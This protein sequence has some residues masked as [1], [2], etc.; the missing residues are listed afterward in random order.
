VQISCTRSGDADVRTANHT[1]VAIWFWPTANITARELEAQSDI[2]SEDEHTRC[3]RM[4]AA[5]DRR[6]FTAA[7]GLLRRVL[8]ANG[9][10]RPEEWRFVTDERGKP[11]I[12]PEQ[13]GDPPLT[14]SL[15]HTRGL[16]ACAVAR[17][18]LIGIDVEA[19]E[20]RSASPDVASRFFAPAEVEMLR[21]HPPETYA[22]RFIEVWTLKESYIKALGV[23]LEQQLDS[24]AFFFPNDGGLRFE[25]PPQDTSESWRFVLCAPSSRFRLAVAVG[26]GDTDRGP[27]VTFNE[28]PT[29]L[30]VSEGLT[31]RP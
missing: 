29:I 2:L 22:D 15:S 27:I 6:D 16:V 23:G 3:D 8:S 5:V 13:A 4:L 21:G 10:V 20:E 7:H 17:V 12:V 1:D 28:S 18:P 30:R 25:A 31:V 24:F 9:D 11:S 14:F 19:I 26:V